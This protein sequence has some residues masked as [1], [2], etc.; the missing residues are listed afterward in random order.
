M[1]GKLKIAVCHPGKIGD[2]I[3][4]LP[5]IRR[6]KE[7]NDC[8]VDFYTSEL[9][10]SLKNL[11]EY[12]S[13]VD[14]FFVVPHEISHMGQGIQPWKMQIDESSYSKVFQLGFDLFPQGE[15]HKSYCGKFGS[16][17]VESPYYEYPQ[18]ANTVQ[19]PYVVISPATR[20]T[21]PSSV[22]K[23]IIDIAPF[24][25]I[26]VG[27]TGEFIQSDSID[28]TGID[29]ISSLPILNQASGFI[30]IMTSMLALANGFPKLKKV[31]LCENDGNRLMR[32]DIHYVSPHLPT[33]KILDF[34][35]DIV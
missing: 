5:S 18:S 27:G 13:C 3:Y 17:S 20:N 34:F 2:A 16:G 19:E 28:K 9:C 1:I 24:K 22:F 11:F 14:G 25:V 12:Q 8:H 7:F 23:N 29:F 6:F 32:E 15:L 10:A 35:K 21:I 30:S 4:T 31:V 33:C 26:Q